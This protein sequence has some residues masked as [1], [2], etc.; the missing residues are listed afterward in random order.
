M[1]KFI[2]LCTVFLFLNAFVGVSFLHA[3]SNTPSRLDKSERD[4]TKEKRLRQKIEAPEVKTEIRD[5]TQEKLDAQ[6][7][8]LHDLEVRGTEEKILIKKIEVIDVT[9]FPLSKIRSITQQYENKELTLREIHR[10][11]DLIT[12]AYRQQG[13]VTSRAYIPPHKIVDGVLE[14]KVVEGKTG[15]IEFKGNRYFSNR[16]LHKK[17]TLKKGDIFNYNTLRKDMLKINETPDC[18][19]SALLVP[20]KEP[21]TTDVTLNV[22]DKLPIH[23]GLG[24]DNFASRFVDKNRYRT[25]LT[26]N[27]LLGLGDIA[28]LTYQI[29]DGQYYKFTSLRYVLPVTQ[30]LELGFFAARSYLSLRRDFEDLDARGK[31]R[32]FSFFGTQKLIHEENVNL[33]LTFGFDYKNIYNF[34][35]GSTTSRDFL[36]IVK[37]GIDYDLTDPFGRTIIINELDYGIPNIMGGMPKKDPLSSRDGAGG[38][39]LKDTLDLVRLQ[40]MPLD[41]N[42]LWKNELQFSPYILP[43]SEQFQI[44]GTVNVRGYPPAEVVGDQGFSSTFEWSFPVYFLPRH[45]K[46]PLSAA[47]L[48]DAVRWVAFYDWANTRLRRPLVGEEKNK[49]LRSIG[50]GIRIT[51]PEDFSARLDIAWPLDQLP[52]DK[53]H[54]HTWIEISK[55]F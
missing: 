28:T 51:L 26:D 47:K 50:T 53:K 20:G 22:K 39:F 29:S 8:L 7:K 44:G 24:Y 16:L 49:T 17:I 43:A 35:A 37:G 1:K 52:S 36:R 23:V 48:Y 15:D 33:D 9:I 5:E 42:L 46:F 6:E 2:I 30:S 13:Y 4:I 54:V 31:S 27:N 14:L 41:S 45:V 18:N 21:G 11:V 25:T 3:Q 40:K 38:E 19:A 34:Q 10:I 12:D 55:N 32:L